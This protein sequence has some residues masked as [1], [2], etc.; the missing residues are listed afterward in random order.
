MESYYCIVRV[1]ESQEIVIRNNENYIP[2]K[3][4]NKTLHFNGGVY[5]VRN[6]LGFLYLYVLYI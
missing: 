5:P 2:Y 1:V 3:Y 4:T 6:C